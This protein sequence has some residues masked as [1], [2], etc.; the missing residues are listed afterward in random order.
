[1]KIQ[2]RFLRKHNDKDYYKYVVNLPPMV[3][4]EAGIKYGEDVEVK[5][6]K[7]KIVLEKKRKAKNEGSFRRV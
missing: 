2:K 7:G 6:E 5:T 4:K 1:M 3:L